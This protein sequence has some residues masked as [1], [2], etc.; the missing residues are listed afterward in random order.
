MADFT[1]E[2]QSEWDQRQAFMQRLHT[3]VMMCAECLDFKDFNGWLRNIISLKIDLSAHINKEDKAIIDSD[4]DKAFSLLKTN[5]A[6]YDKIK[7]LTSIQEKL[8]A[9]MRSRKFDVP[10]RETSPGSIIKNDRSY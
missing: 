8:H 1:F 6:E 5:M 9:V 3:R 2:G 10:I 4:I 7:I